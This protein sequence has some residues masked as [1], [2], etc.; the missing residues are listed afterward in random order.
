MITIKL[1]LQT[2][3]LC[4]A[5]LSYSL[6][7]LQTSLGSGYI[8]TLSSVLLSPQSSSFSPSLS[9]EVV[10]FFAILTDVTHNNN[11]ASAATV[12][13][14]INLLKSTLVF[15]NRILHS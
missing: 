3:S 10:V 9:S 7:L 12:L 1:F 2:A 15:L 11:T 14:T 6:I 4:F 13:G 5:A 8:L